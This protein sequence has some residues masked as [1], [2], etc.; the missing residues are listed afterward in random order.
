MVKN[1]NKKHCF[2]A[3]ALAYIKGKVK[4]DS[5]EEAKRKVRYGEYD[6]LSTQLS[7]MCSDVEITKIE[8]ERR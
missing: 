3:E 6:L 5:E 8:D 1:M 7:G 4:A 2:N